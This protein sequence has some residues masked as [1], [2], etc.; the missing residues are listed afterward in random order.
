M[1]TIKEIKSYKDEKAKIDLIRDL[2]ELVERVKNDEIEVFAG[3][4]IDTNGDISAY[5]AR[6]RKT[7]LIE[8]IGLVS[9][10]DDYL[11][12]IAREG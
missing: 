2:E 7:N 10:L 4:T 1:A 3:T 5:H 12:E 9:M 6:L 8:V 11:R